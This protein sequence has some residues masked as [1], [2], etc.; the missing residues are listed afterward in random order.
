MK[1]PKQPA[2]KAE[3][4]A[5]VRRLVTLIGYRC[6]ACDGQKGGMAHVNRGDQPHTWEFIPCRICDGKGRITEEQRQRI[7][8]GQK[9]RADRLARDMSLYEEAR[10]LGMTSVQLSDLECGRLP[11]SAGSET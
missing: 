5:A 8:T 4:D 10:R 1:Y 7:I 11:R 2:N 9:L 3:A 6:T